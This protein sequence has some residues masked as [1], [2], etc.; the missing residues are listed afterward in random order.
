MNQ[1]D[2]KEVEDVWKVFVNHVGDSLAR[3]RPLVA[4]GVGAGQ[5]IKFGNLT[6]SRFYIAEISLNVTF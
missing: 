5:Q 4:Y 2:G 3:K 1:S 6:L